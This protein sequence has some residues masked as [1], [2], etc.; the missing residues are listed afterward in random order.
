MAPTTLTRE[1][2]AYLR[3]EL[4]PRFG[5]PPRLS[6]GILLRAWKSGPQSGLPR[7]PVALKSLVE[8]G[9]MEVRQPF[10]KQPFRAFWT[11]VGLTVLADALQDRRAFDPD[12][13]RHVASELEADQQ[14]ND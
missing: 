6:D 9:L 10:P 13:Y 1:E 11:P 2:I 3:S 5:T 8:R 12:R 14:S 7:L 4:L